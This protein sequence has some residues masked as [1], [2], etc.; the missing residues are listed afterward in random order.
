MHG[1]SVGQIV[2]SAAGRDRGKKFIVLCII[3]SQYVY[4]SDGDIR[5]VENPKKKKVKHLAGTNY[6]SQDIERKA[7]TNQKITNSELRKRLKSM[8]GYREQEV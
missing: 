8:D 3:D 4:I 5:P 2:I 1:F 6:I 7:E